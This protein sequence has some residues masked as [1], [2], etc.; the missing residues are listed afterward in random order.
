MF[1]GDLFKFL[2]CFFNVVNFFWFLFLLG[3][4]GIFFGGL[5]GCCFD[6]VQGFFGD[7]LKSCGVVLVNFWPC[8]GY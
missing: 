5:G 2:C 7:C 3:I 1:F 8:S 4:V 6:D